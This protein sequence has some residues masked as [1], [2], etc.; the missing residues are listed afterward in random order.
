MYF[1][2]TG[3][4]LN[5]DC[6]LIERS[7]WQVIHV[8]FF[9]FQIFLLSCLDSFPHSSSPVNPVE[10]KKSRL[11]SGLCSYSYTESLKMSTRVCSG[12]LLA[13][14]VTLF[15]RLRCEVDQSFTHF[16]FPGG[17][18]E[19][20]WR[21]PASVGLAGSRWPQPEDLNL[22]DICRKPSHCVSLNSPKTIKLLDSS[23]QRFNQIHRPGFL[24]W[25]FNLT[26]TGQD[27]RSPSVV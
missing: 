17:W 2:C 6:T 7:V 9:F 25:H 19:L 5:D 20:L 8:L 26:G 10:W 3:Y 15:T 16:L 27:V 23:N 12:F 14:A 21:L 4:Y 24:D 18:S 22:Q 1:S 13:S 11:K